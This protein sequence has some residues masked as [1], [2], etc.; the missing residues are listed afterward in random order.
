VLLT[1]GLGFGTGYVGF[2]GK[3]G[4]THMKEIRWRTW[5]LL[6]AMAH[7]LPVGPDEAEPLISLLHGFDLRAVQLG[8]PLLEE[9]MAK[10]ELLATWCAQLE[11]ASLPISALGGYR[12]LVAPDETKREANIAFLQR[13][14]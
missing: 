1:T 13:C 11:A 8:T 7:E 10:E 4:D 2:A 14:L 3:L 9:L 6:G 12:N 5:P